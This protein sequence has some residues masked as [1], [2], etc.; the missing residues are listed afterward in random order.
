MKNCYFCGSGMHLLN[1]CVS[2]YTIEIDQWF[3][4]KRNVHSHHQQATE[5]RYKQTVKSDP[6]MSMSSTKQAAV[7]DYKSVCN[8]ENK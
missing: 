4:R 1:N 5:K 6:D 7:A 3:D 8:G 2:R